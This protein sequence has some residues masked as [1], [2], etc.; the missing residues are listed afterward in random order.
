MDD[1]TKRSLKEIFGAGLKAVDPQEAVGRHVQLAGEHLQV[2]GRTYPLASFKRIFVI[3]FG[4]GTAPMAK[5]LEDILGDRLTAGWITVKY[6]HG[7]PLKKVRVMEAGHPIPDESGRQATR[8]ILDRLEECTAEDL[9]LGAFSGGGSALSPAPRAPLELREKQKTTQLLLDCGATISELNA[10]R[11]HLSVCKGGQLAKLA[12]PATLVSLFLS[13]VVGDPLEVIASGPTVPDSSTFADCLQVVERYGLSD[14]LPAAVLKLLRDGAQGLIEETPKAG[15]AIFQRVQNL[16]V[17]NNRAA[18][19]AAAEKAAQLGYH[20]LILSSY[21]QGEAREI[22]HCFAA[23]GKEIAAS[24]HPVPPPACLL[25]GGETTVTRRGRGQGGRNQELALAAALQLE[26]WPRIALLSAGTD[27]T[28]GPTEAAGAFADGE[29]CERAWQKG[30]NPREYLLNNDSYNFFNELG[31]LLIT[32]PTRT[33]VMD[34]ICL[35]VE[36]GN[37]P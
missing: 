20:T 4:K 3:G 30:I 31:D 15:D 12:Y 25:A 33:N 11:K 19:L 22:A 2:G 37:S 23:L 21:M 13:D 35:L 32:G 8:V 7:M 34:V 36:A 6:G 5:A 28:D 26:G 18:L 9:V 16:I 17:G 24:G 27:G 10:I 1:T 29:T 14:K